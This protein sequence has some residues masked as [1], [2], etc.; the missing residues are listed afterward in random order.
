MPAPFKEVD[1]YLQENGLNRIDFQGTDTAWGYRENEPIF[2]IIQS[3]DG[4][5]AFQSAMSL[6]WAA[7]EY[8]MKPWCLFLLVDEL[9]PH[10]MQMLENLKSQYNIQI[11]PIGDSLLDEVKEQL[12]KLVALLDEYI[13]EDSENPSKA[14]G[15]SIR[16]WREKKP[17]SEY[18]YHVA[19]ETGNLEVYMEN[20]QLVP[21]RKTIP[22]TAASG[23]TRIDGI[24]PRLMS[25]ED[26]L[27]FDTEHRNLPMVFKLHIGEEST[28]V[29]RFEADKCNIIE[30]AS[31]W[32]LH[33]DYTRTKKL[34]FIEP[35]TGDILFSCRGELDDRGT[36]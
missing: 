13:P 1:E 5:A 28:L 22:L 36:G 8:I 29:T 27:S 3:S 6:Y 30:A 23:E 21:S 20:G 9:A 11:I 7:A 25:I 15:E 31:Y 16:N 26:G 24:L 10:F 12:D 2:A 14:L 17:A 32:S 33:K 35:N 19:I 34:A 18:Q 4:G